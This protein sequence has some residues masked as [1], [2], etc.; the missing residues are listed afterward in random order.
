MFLAKFEKLLRFT[1]AR[2]IG[3]H[4]RL[5]DVGSW[6][7]AGGIPVLTPFRTPEQNAVVLDVSV[8]LQTTMPDV[9]IAAQRK[10]YLWRCQDWAIRLH[11]AC[12]S[13]RN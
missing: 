3:S 12:R 1:N 10:K 7:T 6:N 13:S 11:C 2:V 9:A 5:E 8:C 4:K